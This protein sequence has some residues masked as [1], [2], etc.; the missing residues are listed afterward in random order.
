MTEKEKA[1]RL[2]EICMAEAEVLREREALI[3]QRES[4]AFE[5]WSKLTKERE[6]A[7]KAWFEAIDARDAAFDRWMQL[8]QQDHHAALA[9]TSP[10][11]P[12]TDTDN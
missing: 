3:S 2:Y 6:I 10:T 9:S 8:R 4:E 12:D 11:A 5:A 1:Q 7:T